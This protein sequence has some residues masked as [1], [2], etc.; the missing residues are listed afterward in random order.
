MSSTNYLG[1][2]IAFPIELLFLITLSLKP[3]SNFEST[4]DV[5]NLNKLFVDVDL[6]NIEGEDF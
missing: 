6:V 4:K 2:C 1:G 3:S 5:G